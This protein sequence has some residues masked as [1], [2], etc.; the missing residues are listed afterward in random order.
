MGKTR[1]E[2]FS[3]GVLAIVLTIMVLEMK[4]PHGSDFAAL[5]PLLPA[6][7]S[8]ILSFIYIGIYW[9]NHHHLLH[10]V[11][12][13]NGKVL[14]LNNH[15]LFWLS[16]VPFAT[17]WMGENHFATWPVVIYGI[18]LLM[19]IMAYYILAKALV[20]HNINNAKLAK[21]VGNDTK[22]K[23]SV[24][25]YAIAIPLNFLHPY[26]GCVF[27]ILVAMMWLIPDKRIEKGIG[28]V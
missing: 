13:I 25:I 6:F 26:I 24:I 22:G 1:M 7:L 27:Y 17:R 14:W 16:L 3:D 10:I 2:A 28:A 4:I 18:I 19:A 15:L 12:H 5:K 21:A 8:Y 9:N 11:Q 23:I 20:N